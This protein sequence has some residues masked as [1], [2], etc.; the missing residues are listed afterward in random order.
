MHRATS[1]HDHTKNPEDQQQEA[2]FSHNSAL[3][4][5]SAIDSS[6]LGIHVFQ[7]GH[8]VT[9]GAADEE[10]FLLDS[11]LE[12]VRSHENCFV[13][14][15]IHEPSYENIVPLSRLF[16]LGPFTVED[17]M[18]A[19]EHPKF[20]HHADYDF[21]IARN[22]HYNPDPPKGTYEYISTAEVQIV[23]GKD[24]V[25]TFSHSKTSTLTRSWRR[26]T[27]TPELTAL[28][29][30]SVFYSVL[31]I[32]VDGYIFACEQ[33]DTAIDALEQEIFTPNKD[34]HIEPVYMLKRETLEMRR[35]IVPLRSVLEDIHV[36]PPASD[37]IVQAQFAD[38]SDHHQLAQDMV[39]AHNERLD[40]LLDAAV[41]KISLQQNTDMR[42]MSAWAALAVAPTI[43]SGIFGMNFA[44]MP[45]LDWQYGFYICLGITLSICIILWIIFRHNKWL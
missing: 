1:P 5:E 15:R 23:I 31:D 38:I 30:I 39:N 36:Q 13:W 27:T 11:A 20:E 37:S 41:G 17:I 14:A 34:T 19:H 10:Q 43:I 25:L 45:G 4:I 35:A 33:V 42:K 9:P 6:V 12:Y 29:P 40:S 44:I 18:N 22:V 7:D 24:F 28:G 3:A 26:L 21:F 32:S 8:L 2:A 16:N